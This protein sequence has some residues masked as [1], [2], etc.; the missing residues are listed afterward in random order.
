MNQPH[1]RAVLTGRILAQFDV[2][3]QAR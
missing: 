3:S 2:A 1:Q